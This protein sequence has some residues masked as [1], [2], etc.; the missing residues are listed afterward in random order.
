MGEMSMIWMRMPGQTWTGVAASFL[1]MWVV[2]TVA[3][4]LPSLLPMLWRY[5]R[6]ADRTGG[7]NL[8]W[9]TALVGIGYF[10]VWIVFGMA[11][12][13][14]GVALNA[15][16]LQQPALERTV[17][18]LIGVVVLAA[19]AVQFS[20]WKARQLACCRAPPEPSRTLPANAG[21]AWRHGLR[22]GLNCIQCCAGL[23]VALLVIGMMDLRAMVAM[24][25][26]I[27]VERLAP[28]GQRAARA[29]GVVTIAAGLALIYV[30]YDKV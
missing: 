10:F 4:M 29:I 13:P 16:Q 7:T 18:V 25:V 24:T 9:M 27:T 19:G 6:V 23:T 21:T 28:A 8:G 2:M 17:P 20:A 26:A 3:M 15:I 11:A 1:G 30:G 22:L 5:R 12:F 14:V